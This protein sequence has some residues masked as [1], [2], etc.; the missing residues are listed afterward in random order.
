MRLASIKAGGFYQGKSGQIRL[1]VSI[2]G[3]LARVEVIDRAGVYAGNINVLPVGTVKT[4]KVATVATNLADNAAML[5]MK[6]PANHIA[7]NGFAI[8][9]TYNV[10]TTGA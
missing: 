8:F 7:P 4:V 6:N 3:P 1:V 9:L 5:Y 10:L 2:N